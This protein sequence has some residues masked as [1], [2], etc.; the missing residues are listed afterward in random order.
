M[1]VAVPESSVQHRIADILSAYDDFIE[2]NNRR[3][4]LLEESIHLLYR[5]WFV[6]LRFP[7]HERVEG[8]DGVPKDWERCPVGSICEVVRGRSYRTAE[9]KDPAG[10]PFITLKNID[11]GG[12]FRLPGLKSYTGKF[13]PGQVCE[14]GDILVAVTD[15]G[16]KREIVA[17]AGR[18]PFLPSLDG[19]VFSMDLVKVVPTKSTESGFLYWMLRASSFPDEVKNHANGTNVLHLKP[20]RITDY[21]LLMP[22]SG[23]RERFSREVEPIHEQLD[24]LWRANIKLRE[25][26][27]LLL[28]R[29][30]DG[31]IPV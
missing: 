21:R 4:A 9:L 27:D 28:P 2:N 22:P 31:R 10:R 18:V 6:Y 16:Q 26:R 30:V 5:E 24:L 11:R 23:L 19:A 1:P 25:A 17:R 12:G 20:A 7:G 14:P 3:M 29:L 13:K 8:V 15:M